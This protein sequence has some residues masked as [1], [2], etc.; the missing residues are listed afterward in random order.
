MA[1]TEALQEE[2]DQEEVDSSDKEDEESDDEDGPSPILI[3]ARDIAQPV[4]YF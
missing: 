2:V 4:C 3:T 1:S